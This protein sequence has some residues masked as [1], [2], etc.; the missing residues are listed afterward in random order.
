MDMSR[1][2]ICVRLTTDLFAVSVA[3]LGIF[4]ASPARAQEY[5]DPEKLPVLDQLPDPLVMLDGTKVANADDWTYQRKPELKRLF[6]HYMY[7]YLPDAPKVVGTVVS[8]HSDALGRKATLKQISLAFGPADCP[9]VDLLL[10]IPNKRKDDRAPPVVLGLNFKGNH[11][12]LDDGR[13]ALPKSW[14]REEP[15]IENH[16]ATEAGRGKEADAWKIEQAIDRGYAVATIYYGDI[17]PD[18]PGLDEGVH[19]CI[20]VVGSDATATGWGAIAAWAW[21]LQRAVDY[22]VTDQDID[23]K[24]IVVFGHSR[25]GKAALLA[26]AFDERIAAIISHQAGCGGSAPSRRKNPKGESVT[27]INEKYPHWFDGNFKKFDGQENRLPFD[28]H[29]LVAL[30]APRPVLLTNGQR[31]QW[32]DPAG[33]LGVLRAASPVYRLLGAEGIR[34]DAP[35][36]IAKRIGDQL[37]FYTRDIGHTVDKEY[38]NVFLDFAD[39][40]L[41]AVR[42]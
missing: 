16:R 29:C 38:W 42:D 8:Q 14:M 5:P 30:C 28:Q 22:L 31:D 40:R 23:S 20:P 21:G 13:I 33:Q 9:K 3:I 26:G 25:N 36:E 7:G 19:A 39:D 34:N 17:S 4:L 24:R 1:A 37:C 27:A 15:D 41:P 10:V 6:Q 11:T 2:P 12:V 32:A 35:P 18:K